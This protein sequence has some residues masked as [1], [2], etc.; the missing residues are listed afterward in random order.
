MR[1]MSRNHSNNSVRAIVYRTME[2]EFLNVSELNCTHNVLVENA[3]EASPNNCLQSFQS[4]VGLGGGG[5]ARVCVCRRGK[6]ID[7]LG[8]SFFLTSRVFLLLRF[9]W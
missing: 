6:Q 7:K 4:V 2:K 9:V 1:Q 8:S 3:R 5:G